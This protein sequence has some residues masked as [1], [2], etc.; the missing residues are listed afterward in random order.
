LH[1]NLT[2]QYHQRNSLIHHLDPRVKVVVTLL[3]ILVVGL[4]RNGS[5]ITFGVLFLGILA[6]AAASR[7]GVFF[8]VRRSIIAIPFLLAAAPLPFLIPGPVLV[9]LPA[10][11]LTISEP[12]MI[13]FVSILLRT[14]IAVQAGILLTATTSFPDLAWAMDSLRI[15]RPLVAVVA[16]MYR[17]IFVMADEVVRLIRARS[18]RSP[19]IP[20][21]RK[22]SL[23]WRGRVTGSMV[24]SLFLRSLDRSE[25]VYGAMVSRGYDGEMRSYATFEMRISDWISLVVFSLLILGSLS[26]MFLR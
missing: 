8:A 15:P 23:L 17:Y 18:A 2:D 16:F 5:W 24:G 3:F 13:R 20:G 6:Y 11:N 9:D 10:L 4:V 19:E 26:L 7:L 1:I 14:F 22:P 25:R 12:G 21:K